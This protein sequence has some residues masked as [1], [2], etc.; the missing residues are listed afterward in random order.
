MKVIISIEIG[1]EYLKIVAA[2]RTGR[3][4]RIVNCLTVSI[5]TL[6]SNDIQAAI[7]RFFSANKYKPLT[8]ELCLPR[9]FVTARNLHLPSELPE[10]ITKM[11]NLSV[12]RIVPYKKEEVTFSY[13][14]SGKDTMEYTRIVLAIVQNELIRKQIKVVEKNG[15]LV[16]RVTLSS[17]GIWQR[18]LE[19]YR[20]QIKQGELCLI[21]DV[22]TTFT[23]FIIFDTENLLFTHNIAIKIKELNTEL[24]LKKFLGEARQ[25]LLMFN[26]EEVEKKTTKIFLSG[27]VA[28][29]L[30][31][32]I[33]DELT[34][35]VTIVP[36]PIPEEVWKKKGRE[37]S[38]ETSLTAVSNMIF[39][40][41]SRRLVLELP[42]LQLRKS[43]RE[44]TKG[45]IIIGSVVA[46]FLLL[47]TLIFLG[48]EH[49]K[50]LYLNEIME[51]SERLEK[52]TEGILHKV[53]RNKV[54]QDYINTRS[55]PLYVIYRLQRSISETIAINFISIDD[56][57][58]IILRGQAIQL[59]EIFGLVTQLE[60]VSNFKNVQTNYTR[61]V[62]VTDGSATDF[63]LEFLLEI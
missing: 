17:Y 16:D 33:E 15:V 12:S 4:S 49:N 30:K 44:K 19:L 14:L 58:K 39:A 41:N 1:E 32:V 38:E 21:L 29:G 48:R 43:M 22:D 61:K 23:D 46:C 31:K 51:F 42:E 5:L 7:G 35:P 18:V 25:T 62:K 6:N 36:S 34:I 57:N 56:E 54:V 26:S 45:L 10:E 52:D 28:E 2:K 24:G 50:Q 3:Q 37:I 27:K 13:R 40:D 59:S 20:N 53:N 9:N 47:L 8:V 55:V 60:K 63:E 11:I